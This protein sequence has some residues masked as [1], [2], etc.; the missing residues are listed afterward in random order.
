MKL[1]NHSAIIK[2]HKNPFGIFA[3]IIIYPLIAYGLWNHSF[4]FVLGIVLEILNWTIIPK[5]NETLPFIQNTIDIELAWWNAPMTILKII[6]I[7]LLSVFIVG[8]FLGFWNHILSL[9]AIS[10]A[11]MIVFYFLMRKVAH[12]NL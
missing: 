4:Y 5:V 6:S 11:I 8:M 1:S 12:T 2:R 9:I 3:R 10:F 7:G